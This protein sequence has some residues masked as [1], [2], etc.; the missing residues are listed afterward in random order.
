MNAGGNDRG[1][2]SAAPPHASRVITKANDNA[3]VI[4][5]PE[6]VNRERKAAL[7]DIETVRRDVAGSISPTPIA[8][9]WRARGGH[10]R[11]RSSRR[12]QAAVQRVS[13]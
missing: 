6:Q 1:H 7:G 13:R 2:R 8:A 5:R 3:T 9:P 12:A 4:I 11:F 10:A